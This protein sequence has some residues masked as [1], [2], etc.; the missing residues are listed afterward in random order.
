MMPDTLTNDL[1][2]LIRARALWMRRTAFAMVHRAQL[3][4]PGGDFSAADI[5][6]TLYA[7]VM[8]FDPARPD[9]GGS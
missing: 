8:Q 4:H 9:W 1:P 2:A 5:L 3:G 6:A 7:G